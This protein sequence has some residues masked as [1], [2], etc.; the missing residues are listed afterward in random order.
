MKADARSIARAL[1]APSDD[2]RL[3]LLHGPDEG[4]SRALADRLTKA[5]GPAAER[6]DFDGSTL[7]RDPARLAD[8]AASTSLF[9]DRRFIRVR[10]NG[11]EAAAA[12]TAL[13][14]AER[15]GAPVVVIAPQLK[16]SS[17][18][19][20]AVLAAPNAL[21]FASYA[22]EGPEAGRVVVEMAREA[23]LRM[24]PDTATRIAEDCAG[25]RGR[26]AGEIEK[27]TLFADAAPDRPREVDADLVEQ[28]G[29]GG[30]D[31]APAR[32]VNDAFSGNPVDAAV[33]LSALQQLERT[34]LLRA[35]QRRALLLLETRARIE[36]GEAPDSVLGAVTRTLFWKDKAP[37]T[38]QA[39]AWT[40]AS[41][42]LVVDALI[43]AELGLRGAASGEDALDRVLLDVARTAARRR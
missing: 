7:A 28:L 38:S 22:L 13:L 4:G 6:V 12:V 10:T 31:D 24:S 14:A 40:A 23:G 20:K 37:V 41:A 18:M 27:L 29:S 21:A 17:A 26:I 39:R 1:S 33:A 19:L 16:P 34:P 11:D 9:G 32:L 42:G 3:Y 43:D 30:I 35:A 2:V 5:M 8:E 25:D 15:A 36:S